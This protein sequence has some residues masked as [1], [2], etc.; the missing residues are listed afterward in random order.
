[1]TGFGGLPGIA[2]IDE[3]G[4]VYGKKSGTITPIYKGFDKKSPIGMWMVVS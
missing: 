2:V 1:L 3:S 4:E